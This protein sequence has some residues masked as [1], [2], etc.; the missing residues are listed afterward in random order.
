MD[1]NDSEQDSV[2]GCCDQGAR[3][4]ESINTEKLLM[5]WTTIKFL[6]TWLYHMVV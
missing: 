3:F 6:S 5:S 4:L 1:S 2:P